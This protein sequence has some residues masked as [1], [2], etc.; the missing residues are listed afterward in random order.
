MEFIIAKVEDL[1]TQVPTSSPVK[2]AI[3]NLLEVAQT[4]SRVAY[5][6]LQE[7]FSKALKKIS[8][9]FTT[10]I[11]EIE[12]GLK[13]QTPQLHE[14]TT[15]SEKRYK[16]M[17]KK[18]SISAVAEIESMK[19]KMAAQDQ[20]FR[21][22]KERYTR[23]YKMANTKTIAQH[24]ILIQVVKDMEQRRKVVQIGIQVR[25][26]GFVV[27]HT[28]LHPGQENRGGE[29]RRAKQEIEVQIKFLTLNKAIVY[30]KQYRQSR[31]Q[32]QQFRHQ[33][34]PKML[35]KPEQLNIQRNSKKIW[36][37]RRKDHGESLRENRSRSLRNGENHKR[38]S[39]DRKKRSGEERGGRRK[40][41]A[42]D[43]IKK[44]MKFL[45]HLMKK[46]LQLM[47]Q[48]YLSTSYLQKILRRQQ[49]SRKTLKSQ[50]DMSKKQD[51]LKINSIQRMTLP[52]SSKRSNKNPKLSRQQQKNKGNTE[53]NQFNK[54]RTVKQSTQHDL[55][56]SKQLS[57]HK[58]HTSH[59]AIT[60]SQESELKEVHL[61]A[62]K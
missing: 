40:K 36:K 61:P 12:S 31:H 21:Q 22:S 58:Y 46:H 20:Q 55:R 2:K 24:T 25:N 49:D 51:L 18:S 43:K 28:I 15:R 9:K 35:S 50:R 5:E 60:K 14:R 17:S 45:R 41:E 52:K 11:S 7:C 53:L 56:C 26:T 33:R 47:G 3:C 59:K 23:R 48:Q 8:S 38:G 57:T 54:G 44:Q 1:A 13:D 32:K 29:N 42:E 19:A 34:Q 6:N 39:R 62:R 16:Q 10:E 27:G 30:Q 37:T 4:Q